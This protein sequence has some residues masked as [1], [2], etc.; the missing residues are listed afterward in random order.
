MFRQIGQY[1]LGVVILVLIVAWAGGCA[2]GRAWVRD[3]CPEELYRVVWPFL[4]E[5]GF[6]TVGYDEFEC[7]ELEDDFRRA[8][9]DGDSGAFLILDDIRSNCRR[10]YRELREDVQDAANREGF[11]ANQI[12]C[13]GSER[14]MS[15]ALETRDSTSIVVVGVLVEDSC[16]NEYEAYV[17]ELNP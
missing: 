6:I 2:L 15:E 17:R 9:E 12:D 11:D 8:A 14:A 10:T 13:R 4:R 7:S 3:N 16:P 1:A 5:D